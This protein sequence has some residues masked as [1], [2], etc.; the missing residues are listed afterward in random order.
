MEGNARQKQQMVACK[1]NFF[2]FFF[3]V[4]SYLKQTDEIKGFNLGLKV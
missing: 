4:E 1:R 2:F 3:N